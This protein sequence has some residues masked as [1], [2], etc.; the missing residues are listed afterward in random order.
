MPV[1]KNA[2]I[3]Y[4]VLDKCFRNTGRRYSIDDLVDECSKVLLDIDPD[5]GG[6]SKKQ[7]Y[8]DIAHMAS[9]DGWEIELDKIIENRRVYFRY[10]EP[11]YSI[12]SMP[13]NEIEIEQ[14]RSTLDIL[15]QFK[16]MPQFEWMGDLIIRLD[17][18]LKFDQSQKSIIDFDSNQYL[19]GIEFI[20]DLYNAIYYKKVLKITYRPYQSESKF[21]WTIHP[22]YLKQYNNRW[23]VFCKCLQKEQQITNLALDRIVSLKETKGEYIESDIDWQE[24]FEDFIGVTRPEG[25]EIETIVLHFYGKQSHYIFTKPLHESQR[26]KWLE[27]DLLEVKLKLMINYEFET[28]LMNYIESM[29]IIEPEKL[30][31]SIN[32]RLKK[33]II[34]NQ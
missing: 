16:G 19:K 32:E 13:L 26:P 15:K 27:K 3:R 17:K 25:K 9:S 6:V 10:K 7:I 21:L 23:F 14:L 29:K 34:L 22:Y 33:A 30:R 12:N 8:N 24:Y 4:N 1:N 2:L 28:L 20:G 31:S 18:T 11:G 5:C